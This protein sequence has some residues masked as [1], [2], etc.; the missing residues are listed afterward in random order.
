MIKLNQKKV[1]KVKSKWLNQRSET[2]K[3]YQITKMKKTK[4]LKK[5]KKPLNRMQK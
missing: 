5:I 2:V 1:S 4:L 3:K